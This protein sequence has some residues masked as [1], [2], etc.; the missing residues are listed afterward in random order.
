MW[1]LR[2]SVNGTVF[3]LPTRGVF[4]YVKS[5]RPCRKFLYSRGHKPPE[6]TFPQHDAAEHRVGGGSALFRSR[7]LHTFG[8]RGFVF[9]PAG[10]A[11]DAAEALGLVAGAFGVDRS[12][13]RV[14]S[15][16]GGWRFDDCATR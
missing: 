1:K 12:D 4:D 14:C 15:D 3:D 8:A 5:I 2:T 10:P 11:C 9:I 7:N 13:F 16:G 6:H